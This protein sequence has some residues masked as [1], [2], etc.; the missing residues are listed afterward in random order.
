MKRLLH[1]L[2]LI[3]LAACYCLQA[4]VLVWWFPALLLDWLSGDAERREI[5]RRE[6]NRRYKHRI[7]DEV[8]RRD[9][10]KRHKRVWKNRNDFFK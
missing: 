8:I 7:M 2:G 4:A 9:N 5:F 6:S 3:L 10:E 1:V